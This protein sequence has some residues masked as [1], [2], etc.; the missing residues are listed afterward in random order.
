[1]QEYLLVHQEQGEGFKS[2]HICENLDREF[3]EELPFAPKHQSTYGTYASSAK[4]LPFSPVSAF[5]SM[6]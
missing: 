5:Y 6:A 3:K 1:M 4:P 2:P